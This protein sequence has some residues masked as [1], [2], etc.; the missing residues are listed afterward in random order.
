MKNDLN[1]VLLDLN[2]DFIYLFLQYLKKDIYE[3]Y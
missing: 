2:V 1:V 3:Y